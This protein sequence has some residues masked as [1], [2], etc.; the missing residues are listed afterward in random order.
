[1]SSILTGLIIMRTTS[2][3]HL[4]Q[5]SEATTTLQGG[6]KFKTT[7]LWMARHNTNYQKQ[8][9][10]KKK[11]KKLVIL[12]N[13]SRITANLIDLPL[14]PSFIPFF[15]SKPL[16]SLP[17]FQAVVMPREEKPRSWIWTRLLLLLLLC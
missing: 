4:V 9:A 16:S 3:K 14:L 5:S 11:K 13:E 12:T 10:E 7:K 6:Q 8:S 1:M 15:N 17:C 2:R